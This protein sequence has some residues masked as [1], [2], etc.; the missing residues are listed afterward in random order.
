MKYVQGLEGQSAGVYIFE[1][2]QEAQVMRDMLHITPDH[3]LAAAFRRPKVLARIKTRRYELDAD[4]TAAAQHL[5]MYPDELTTVSG[6]KARMLN[7][8]TSHAGLKILDG[9]AQRTPDLPPVP[10]TSNDELATTMRR[11][12]TAFF[13]M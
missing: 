10:V 2:A 7:H 9:L 5:D 1:A 8:A 4:L 6:Y 11:Q 3:V 13:A 12:V